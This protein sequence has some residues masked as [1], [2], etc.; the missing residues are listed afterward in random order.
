MNHPT[1]PYTVLAD[2]IPVF[3]PKLNEA[4]ANF[5]KFAAFVKKIRFQFPQLKFLV[6]FH[7]KDFDAIT[8]VVDENA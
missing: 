6:H 3:A 2:G 7:V 4:A 1:T 8:I 5:E